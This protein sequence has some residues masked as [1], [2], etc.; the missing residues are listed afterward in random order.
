MYLRKNL[1][2]NTKILNG[3]EILFNSCMFVPSII[4]KYIKQPHMVFMDSA[5]DL[6]CNIFYIYNVIT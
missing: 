3:K 6:G 1:T 5:N 2:K 4:Q